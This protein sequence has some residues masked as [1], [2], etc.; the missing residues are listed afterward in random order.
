M[1]RKKEHRRLTWHQQDPQRKTPS[2]TCKLRSSSGSHRRAAPASVPLG[3]PARPGLRTAAPVAA[4]RRLASRSAGS[5]PR[6]ARFSQRREARTCTEEERRRTGP[7]VGKTHISTSRVQMQGVPP[8]K[9][10]LCF[11]GSSFWPIV[12]KWQE[13]PK[14]FGNRSRFYIQWLFLFSVFRFGVH[15]TL[16]VEVRRVVVNSWENIIF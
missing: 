9:N 8:S 13:R 4:E 14:V 12:L 16:Q 11:A 15:I 6:A 10:W 3:P 1:Q 5:W 2:E 7:A